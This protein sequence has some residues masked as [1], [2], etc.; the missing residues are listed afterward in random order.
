MPIPDWYDLV[1][2]FLD[3]TATSASQSEPKS[4]TLEDLNKAMDLVC[5]VLYYGQTKFITKGTLY[6][7][8][9]TDINPE[10]ILI[11]PDDFQEVKEKITGRRLVPLKKYNIAHA[12]FAEVMDI[13]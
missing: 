9:K 7:I 11:H 6:L 12:L 13:K 10:Y 1:E 3:S 8:K 5:P 2:T 4:L